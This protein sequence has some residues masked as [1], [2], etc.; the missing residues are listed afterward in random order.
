[1]A[2]AIGN[3]FSPDSSDAQ[4]GQALRPSS[5]GAAL[6]NYYD[7]TMERTAKQRTML[8]SR[9]Q[10][11]RPTRPAPCSEQRI[12][13]S[14]QPT[15]AYSKATHHAIPSDAA[16]QAQPHWAMQ[17]VTSRV[18]SNH[19]VH[20]S[21]GPAPKQHTM[22]SRRAP[23]RRPSPMQ[24]VTNQRTKRSRWAQR[25]RPSPLLPAACSKA[26]HHAIPSGAAAQAQPLAA[27][28]KPRTNR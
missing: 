4:Q 3:N 27:C 6:L 13:Q 24:R 19:I 23:S 2:I 11:H 21:A 28:S 8:S 14:R 5:Q 22:R 20:S 7:N 15:A 26:K 17:R 9:A 10:Q 1:M 12:M 16:A 25:R 18:P